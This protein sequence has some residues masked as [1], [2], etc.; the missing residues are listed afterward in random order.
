MSNTQF[1]SI[2]G[3]GRSNEYILLSIGNVLHVG[4]LGGTDEKNRIVHHA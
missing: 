3:N 1:I 4:S 2:Q